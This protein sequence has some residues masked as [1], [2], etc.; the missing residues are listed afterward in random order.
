[1]LKLVVCANQLVSLVAATF[2]WLCVETAVH[3]QH[4]NDF[5][6]AATFGWLCVETLLQ[7]VISITVKKQ[8]PSG[9]CVLKQQNAPK[10]TDS[11]VQP[12]SGGCV[13]KH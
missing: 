5:M 9:G 7:S 13:L 3:C 6:K 10:H 4:P 1:M 2:G 12:P 8:P 11:P